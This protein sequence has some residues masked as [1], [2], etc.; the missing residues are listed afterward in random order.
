[1][2]DWYRID[3]DRRGTETTTFDLPGGPYKTGAA[4]TRLFK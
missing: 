2:P 4:G 3:R 1:M